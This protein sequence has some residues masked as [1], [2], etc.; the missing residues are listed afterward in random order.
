MQDPLTREL[1][2][3]ARDDAF[4]SI[5]LI[6]T[7][8]EFNKTAC[9]YHTWVQEKIIIWGGAGVRGNIVNTGLFVCLFTM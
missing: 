8:T 9:T 2:T 7:S 3:V 6:M 4:N 1:R 5:V